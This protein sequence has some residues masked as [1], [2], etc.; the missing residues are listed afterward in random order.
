VA[1][2]PRGR[3]PLFT[4]RGR[5]A[6]NLLT[7][8]RMLSPPWFTIAVSL[9]VASASF[10]L[11]GCGSADAPRAFSGEDAGDDAGPDAPR[12]DED[13][14][15]E[16]A[17]ETGGPMPS[18]PVTEL[19]AAMARSMCTYLESCS[20]E[21]IEVMWAVLADCEAR[22]RENCLA[23]YPKGAE[24]RKD[25]ADAMAACAAGAACYAGSPLL[26]PAPRLTVT[27]PLGS[28]CRADSECESNSCSGTEREC[29]TCMDR[30]GAGESCSNSAEC[31]RGGY[32]SQTCLAPAFLGDACDP[33][34]ICTNGLTCSGG[35]CVRSGG[36]DASCTSSTDCDLV[37]AIACNRAGGKC[38]KFSFAE[39]DD[40]CPPPFHEGPPVACTKG[41]R[42][43]NPSPEEPGSCVAPAKVGEACGDGKPCETYVHCREGRCVVPT[44]AA[45]P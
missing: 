32:C 28:S 1:E 45:C 41:S 26:C 6:R 9:A 15:A 14:G 40:P 12:T 34:R 2:R 11:P 10:A 7:A 23:A 16:A 3:V 4:A 17:A 5:S 18:V 42:C 22:I 36:V 35:K 27:K 33:H 20:P 24:V 29:G 31:P 43:A 44:Y 30:K 8:P 38:E 39:P 19:C 25:D 37:A 21:L 13:G